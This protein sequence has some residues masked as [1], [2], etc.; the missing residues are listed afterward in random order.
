MKKLI[1]VSLV[2]CSMFM[3]SACEMFT[4]RMDEGIDNDR[5]K[6]AYGANKW[7][8]IVV[9]VDSETGVMYMSDKDAGLVVMVDKDGKP[10]IFDGAAENE[11]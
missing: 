3:L 7:S 9:Y 6:R 4:E 2:L 10:L 8:D 5:I 1:A 11:E